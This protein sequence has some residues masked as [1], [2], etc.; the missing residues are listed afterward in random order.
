MAI[1]VCQ[2]DQSINVHGIA[3][4]FLQNNRLAELTQFLLEC[5]KNNRPEDGVWLTQ[6]LELNLMAAPQV[7]DAILNMEIWNQFNKQKIALL[8]EQKGKI[9]KFNNLKGL[10]QKALEN[11]TEIKDI[12]RIC[13]NVHMLNLEWVVN[14]IGKLPGD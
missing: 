14:Y 13:L 12:K 3:E 4:I 8:C 1:S 10:F 6:V 5:M 2:K 7:A 11:Y 9:L